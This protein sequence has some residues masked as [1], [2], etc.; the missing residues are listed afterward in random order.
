MKAIVICG[1]PGAGKTWARESNP[2]LTGLPFV[3]IS[4]VYDDV[5][6]ISW[7]A[8]VLAIT[9]RAGKLFLKGDCGTVVLEG[10]FLPETP[11]RQ[12]LE[13]EL[14][15]MRL[16]TEFIQVHRRYWECREGILSDGENVK[17]RLELLDLY[18]ERAQR[19]YKEEQ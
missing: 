8:A 14:K 6:D 13:R 12:L 17:K 11:S 10:I 3:D 19:C 1:V 7:D 16:D 5:P 2:G 15:S 9:A 4:G 18:F